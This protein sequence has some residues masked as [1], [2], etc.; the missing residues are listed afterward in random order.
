MFDYV[1]TYVDVIFYGMSDTNDTIA[2][3]DWYIFDK[4]YEWW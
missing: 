1:C 4:W 3:C 2:W